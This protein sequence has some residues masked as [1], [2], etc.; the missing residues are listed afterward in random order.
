L[1][2]I[3]QG[4]RIGLLSAPGRPGRPISRLFKRHRYDKKP[5]A[6]VMKC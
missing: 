5:H 1:L 3:N 6:G 4:I 2:F